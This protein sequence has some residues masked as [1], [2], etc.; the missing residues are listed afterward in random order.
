VTYHIKYRPSTLATVFGQPQA[1]KQLQGFL[2]ASSVPQVIGFY[3]PPGTGKTTLARIMA[4]EVG[5]TAMSINEINVADKNGV[6]DVRKLRDD[7]AMKPLGSKVSVFILDEAHSFS[8]QA[9]QGLLKLFED[10][11]KHCYFFLCTSQPDKIDK[12]IKTRI[13]GIEL[14]TIPEAQLTTLIGSVADSEGLEYRE[15]DFKAIAKAAKGSARNAL[16]YLNQMQACGFDRSV[17]A[18]LANSVDEKHNA[19]PLCSMLMWPKAKSWGEVYAL[20]DGV[21][22]EELEAVR[23]MLLRYAASCMKD[24]KNCVPA[25]NVI[26]SMASP[27]FDSKKPG[28]LAKCSTIWT[29][30]G[31]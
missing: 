16:V 18:D 8:K 4:K 19:F 1:V 22:D 6:E 9:F 2:D 20:V 12:A 27:F 29:K 21:E 24:A 15:G 17:L 28:F 7:A 23:W 30:N 25:R 31:V 10:T 3:G 26:E 5:A 14:K 11:P 13:T